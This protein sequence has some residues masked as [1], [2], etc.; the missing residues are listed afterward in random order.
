MP[1]NGLED[2]SSGR[3]S[4]GVGK[5]REWGVPLPEIEGKLRKSSSDIDHV[6]VILRGVFILKPYS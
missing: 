1:K 2:K 3:G 6:I 5:G 4:V